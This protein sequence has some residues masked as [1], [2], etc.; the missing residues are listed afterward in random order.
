MV[1]RLGADRAET[2]QGGG[3]DDTL[4]GRGGDDR[5]LGLAGDDLLLPGAGANRVDGG[6]GRDAVAFALDEAGEIFGPA[7]AVRA[8]LAAGTYAV[9][10]A[11]TRLAGVEEVFGGLAGDLLAGDG[12]ANGLFGQGGDD[13]LLGRGGDDLLIG[14]DGRD[15][16]LGGAGDDTLDAT[17]SADDLPDDLRGGAGDDLLRLGQSGDA[18]R[19]GAG[20]DQFQAGVRVF[21]DDG[22]GPLFT[23]RDFDP[24]E[25]DVIGLPA[26]ADGDT[27]QRYAFVGTRPL[28][29]N[30][31]A[32]VGFE[33]RGGETVVRFEAAEGD[34]RTVNEFRLAGRVDLAADD[35]LLGFATTDRGD[36]V[37]GTPFGELVLAGP[38]DDRIEGGAGDDLVE[39]G[40][41]D[42]ILTD[43]TGGEASDDTY[44]FAGDFGDD[45]IADFGGSDEA[46][47]RGLDR[48]DVALARDEGDLVLTV[49]ANGSSVRILSFYED[50]V[51]LDLVLGGSRLSAE[52]IA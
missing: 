2:L 8:D 15:V 26:F 10:G 18:A 41:G 43:V 27:Q 49:R 20:A 46:V 13:R 32:E 51:D 21:G 7:S 1:V 4:D 47:F 25:G 5:L 37:T 3:G 24:G 17:G 39:G 14:G 40:P 6:P 52:S 31:R 36:R 42:D 22:G 45:E 34:L 30:G 19:G 48:S 23:I 44:L 16:V 28:A 50:F 35:F 33:H 9:G 29:A 11:V 12:L 38:G